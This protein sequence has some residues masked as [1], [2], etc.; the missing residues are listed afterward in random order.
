MGCLFVVVLVWMQYPAIN[1]K[2]RQREMMLRL[3]EKGNKAA[4]E[5]IWSIQN[6]LIMLEEM[7]ALDP[8]EYNGEDGQE[9]RREILESIDHFRRD[10]ERME[11]DAT[12]QKHFERIIE[13]KRMHCIMKMMAFDDLRLFRVDDRSDKNL[14]P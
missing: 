4:Q 11:G 5:T 8:K 1:K 13:L 14:D 6:G 2:K 12:E 3:F 9:R 10:I 7:R